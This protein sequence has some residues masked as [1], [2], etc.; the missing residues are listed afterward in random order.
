[1]TPEMKLTRTL[2]LAKHSR[3]QINP[4]QPAAQWPLSD[5]GRR[6]CEALAKALAP[7]QP[8]IIIASEERKAAQTGELTAQRLGIPWRTAPGLHEHDRS[9][10][11]YLADEAAFHAR[12]AALF[13]RPDER[14]FG[15][16]T[17]HEALTRFSVALDA[18][19]ADTV[20]TS[21]RSIA[22]V[23]HGTVISL[24]VADRFGLDGFALWRRLGLPALVVTDAPKLTAPLEI[25]QIG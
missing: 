4:M 7:W 18:A 17:A 16:E 9:N 6:R 20:A 10:A 22:V 1:M 2:I 25:A 15:A 21:A 14:V 19:L 3:P 5:E 12:V 8:E 23:A 24:Y 11:L 13:A